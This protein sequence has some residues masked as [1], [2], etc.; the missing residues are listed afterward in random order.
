ML[1][2]KVFEQS[3]GDRWFERNRG[4]LDAFDPDLDLPTKLIG[5]YGLRPANVL[6]IGAASGARLAEIHA[7]NGA[8]VVALEPSSRAI[9]HGKARFPSVTFIRGTAMSVPLRNCF[10]LVIVNFVFH[11]ID[12]VNLF[13]SM[14]EIDRLVEDGG[15]L[16]IGDFYPSNC[17]QIRYH[18]LPTT[19]L[20]TFK[21]NYAAT[22]VASGLYHPTGLLTGSHGSKNLDAGASEEKRVGV[23]LLR[24][25]TRN[26]YI[27]TVSHESR[28]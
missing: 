13:R 9:L 27:E 6:E 24:K 14:A 5:L 20:Y 7:R 19:P 12:R 1:Q 2:D 22:F 25:E 15:F 8:E 4:A 17:R 16:L 28:A 11:W 18:H 3:E 10:D 21:Q 26:H 23:W